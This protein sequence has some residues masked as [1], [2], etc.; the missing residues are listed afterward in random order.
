MKL[1][2]VN[3]H[4]KHD[5]KLNELIEEKIG[6]LDH[7][8]SAHARQSA[9]ADVKI[10]AGPGRGEKRF[11]CEVV[12][13]LPKEIVTTNQEAITAEAAVD[14]AA[15]KLKN[16]LKKYK[17]KHGLSRRHRLRRRFGWRKGQNT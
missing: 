10:K 11:I 2:I 14:L 1:N 13:H 15:D 5:P 8:L 17:D 3:R 12:I 16:Q 7:M 4:V 6:N 9:H